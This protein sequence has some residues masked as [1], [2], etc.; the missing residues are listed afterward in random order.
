MEKLNVKYIKKS[1][2]SL[3]TSGILMCF[4]FK[5]NDLLSKVVILLFFIFSIS[6]C[7]RNL[8]LVFRKNKI[9]EKVS[10]IYEIAFFTYWFGFLIY[11]DYISIMNKNYT[12]VIF[13]LIMWIGGGYFVY[14]RFFNNKSVNKGGKNEK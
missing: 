13:S 11:C 10:K 1:I 9:A 4:L 8:L 5:T 7:T 2:T 12:L 3:I 14:K 6:F